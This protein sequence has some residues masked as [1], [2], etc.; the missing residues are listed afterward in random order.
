M[1][2]RLQELDL[3]AEDPSVKTGGPSSK[4]HSTSR[5]SR[6]RFSLTFDAE[7]APTIEEVEEEPY[8]PARLANGAYACNH[9]CGSLFSNFR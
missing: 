5:L 9:A 7:P 3:A 4:S 1:L 8:I 6:Q 2:I